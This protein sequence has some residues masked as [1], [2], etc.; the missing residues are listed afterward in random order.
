MGRNQSGNFLYLLGGK[1]GFFGYDLGRERKKSGIKFSNIIK[2]KAT[3]LDNYW[4]SRRPRNCIDPS[5]PIGQL[6]NSK[7]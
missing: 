3:V 5:H 1:S 2:R 4:L 7:D 6:L